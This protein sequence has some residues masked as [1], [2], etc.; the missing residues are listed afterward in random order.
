MWEYTDSYIFSGVLYT[1]FLSY[2][3]NADGTFSYKSSYIYTGNY[4]VSN[5]KITLTRITSGGKVYNDSVLEYKIGKENG[6]DY[7]QIPIYSHYYESYQ[8]LTDWSP[9]WIKLA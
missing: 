1:D 9:K 2:K 8:G 6:K 3:F 5:G 7:L 4:K